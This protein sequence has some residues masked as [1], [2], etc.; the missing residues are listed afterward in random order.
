MNDIY[1][2]KF[3]TPIGWIYTAETDRGLVMISLGKDAKRRFDAFIRNYPDS[4]AI[5]GGKENKKAELQIKSYLDGRLKKFTLKLDRG[6]TPFQRKALN[7]VAAI[8]YGKVKTYGQIAAA[9]GKPGAAR[10]VGGANAGNPLP[11]V[12]PCHRVVAAGGLG[13]YAGDVK[14]KKRLLQLEGAIE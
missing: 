6:G 8:P 11:L 14:I 12:I 9:L 3:N 1:T 7:K 10:A 2:H 13:G 4:R 5:A